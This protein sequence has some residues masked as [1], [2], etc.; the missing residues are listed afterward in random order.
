MRTV[1]LV[2]FLLPTIAFSQTQQVFIK[3]TDNAGQQIRGEVL[4]KGFE[5]AMQIISMTSGGKNNTQLEFT[6]Q[7]SGASADL[8]RAMAGGSRLATGEVSVITP[9]TGAGALS[10]TIKMEQMTVLSCAEA[11]GCN[12]TMTT[13][14]SLQ[15]TRIGW[16]YY[17][18]NRNGVSAVSRKYGWDSSTGADW[19]NF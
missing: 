14:V 15:A 9:N 1:I 13:T 6:M 3:L 11:M 5:R 8:K 10:Y 4:I 12:S 2:L 18:V 19:T 16:T 17:A 7:I